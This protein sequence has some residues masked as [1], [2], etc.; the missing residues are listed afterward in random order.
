M[1][2]ILL[3]ALM[4]MGILF[5]VASAQP[6]PKILIVGDS[7]AAG[8]GVAESE[9]WVNLLQERLRKQGFPHQIINA[10][11]SGDTS[12]SGA[13]RIDD[14]L[15]RHQPQLVVIELG[16]NDGLR[17]LPLDHIRQNLVTMIERSRNAGARVV[18]VGMQ[19]PP[20]YGPRYADAFARLF[21]DLA[22]EYDTALVERFLEEVGQNPTLMQSDGIHPATAAQPLLME[23]IWPVLRSQLF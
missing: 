21:P 5:A 1:R 20:N 4:V 17:G 7:I 10:A 3:T 14:L 12:A 9:A 18:L 6:T 19:I 8:Y 2:S 13:S 22:A 23:R 15:Q 11:I 16:G